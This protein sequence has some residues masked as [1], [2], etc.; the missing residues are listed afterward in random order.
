M[1]YNSAYRQDETSTMSNVILQYSR[2]VAT[3]IRETFLSGPPP[4][5]PVVIPP[6][7]T[8]SSLS[9]RTNVAIADLADGTYTTSDTLT[10]KET[11]IDAGSGGFTTGGV[12]S[13]PTGGYIIGTDVNGRKYITSVIGKSFGVFDVG[14]ES[15]TIAF[16]ASGKGL[17][18][19]ANRLTYGTSP[20]DG[21]NIHLSSRMIGFYPLDWQ[22]S[23]LVASQFPN[24][25][26]ADY[27]LFLVSFNQ[28]TQKM[29]TI[30]RT[31]TNYSY[32][33]TVTQRSPN[34]ALGYS[35][36]SASS[37]SFSLVTQNG[38][39]P[40]RIY[41][42]MIFP[43]EYMTEDR[44]MYPNFGIIENY[45]DTEYGIAIPFPVFVK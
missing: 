34:P 24:F 14:T 29:T 15:F 33:V 8:I 41:D 39:V 40:L 22:I 37:R 36:P 21:I 3:Q 35:S 17:G 9:F 26:N 44:A 2:N 4:P 23:G 30:L 27:C 13:F 32:Q 45:L 19:G 16:V 1:S 28:D 38:E 20:R 7:E 6:I 11:T 42:M 10:Y 5:P 25:S 43:G 18:L 12:L 31:N